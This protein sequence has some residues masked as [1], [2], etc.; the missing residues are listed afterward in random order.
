[1]KINQI[2][3][4]P[5]I[6][7]AHTY[8]SENA[9]LYI[10]GDDGQRMYKNKIANLEI[11]VASVDEVADVICMEHNAKCAYCDCHNDYNVTA[12]A[13]REKYHMIPK[14]LMP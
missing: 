6:A 5:K 8:A 1:M 13:L 9:D 14:E 10:A 11:P 4:L 2:V 12:K 3:E 7:K